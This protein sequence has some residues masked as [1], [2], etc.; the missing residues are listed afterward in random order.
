MKR[1]VRTGVFETNS[2]SMH[3][4]SINGSDMILKS[5][6]EYIFP[7]SE[8]F[9]VPTDDSDI[10]II[11]L[12]DCEYG[13]GYEYITDPFE[14]LKYLVMMVVETECKNV[15]C[16]NEIYETEGFKLIQAEVPH[17]IVI[18]DD[19]LEQHSYTNKEND[20]VY[21]LSHSGY[22][23][24]Q[25]HEDFSSLQDFLNDA[26]VNVEEFLYNKQLA[27]IMDNDNH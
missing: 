8:D 10:I 7:L 24:H 16:I 3:S 13:W 9:I 6:R 23:D 2:S 18:L 19:S 4:I 20:V 21:Y 15:T 27:V 12:E 11:P 22:I 5:E 25:S 1:V 14:K 26:D 17:T